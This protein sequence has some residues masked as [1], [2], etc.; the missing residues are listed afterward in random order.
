MNILFSGIPSQRKQDPPQIALQKK[1]DQTV[2]DWF[3]LTYA[4]WLTLPRV[5]LEQMPDEWQYKFTELMREFDEMW[6]WI[7]NDFRFYVVGRENGKVTKLPDYLCEYRHPI[8][9]EIEKI[10]RKKE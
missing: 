6:D 3:E 5:L 8:Q 9:E 2:N 10:R 4:R 1:H 7:P